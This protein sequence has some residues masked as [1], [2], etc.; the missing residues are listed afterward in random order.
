VA[1][2]AAYLYLLPLE[3]VPASKRVAAD[4]AMAMAGARGA[5]ISAL[6]I[7]SEERG[8]I[9]PRSPTPEILGKCVSF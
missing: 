9:F 2:N 4:A 7:L 6:G 8:R 3:Q 5:A 1:L